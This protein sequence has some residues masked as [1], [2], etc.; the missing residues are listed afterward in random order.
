MR[1]REIDQNCKLQL[2]ANTSLLLGRGVA[3]DLLLML[4][5]HFSAVIFREFAENSIFEVQEEAKQPLLLHDTPE[6]DAN[7]GV[8]H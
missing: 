6:V 1:I 7:L 8:R 3:S 2:H 4:K 5:L